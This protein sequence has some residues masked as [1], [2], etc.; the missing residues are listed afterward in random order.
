METVGILGVGDMGHIVAKVLISNG[1]RVIT[2]LK[3]RSERSRYLAKVANVEE[4]S[5]YKELVSEA[6]IILSMVVPS[7]SLQAVQVIVNEISETNVK[8]IF[9][10]CNSIAPQTALTMSEM[11]IKAGGGFIDVSIIGNA[12]KK[13][14]MTRFYASGPDVSAFEKFNQFGLEV[15]PLGERVGQ[16][17]AL[18]MCYAALTKG[19]TALCTEL[20]T[21]AEIF[22]ITPNLH[23][24][25]QLTRSTLYKY[26]Q[27]KVPKMPIKSRRWVGE[28]EEIA[29]TFEHLG[30]TEKI[31]LGAAD[32]YRFVGKTHF[33]DR[34][35]EDTGPH[36]TLNQMISTLASQHLE[37]TK[38]NL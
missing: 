32:I 4:V 3:D 25:F 13:D 17:K 16:A 22:G 27:E 26:M 31:L 21:A 33:A 28:M 34:A 37:N 38:R 11:V 6:E 15:I 14:G 19:L 10:D 24:E 7:Q 2:C 9:A 30:M 20:L 5:T 29:K 1:L 18:K 36:P 8:V 23:K 12:P 35:P